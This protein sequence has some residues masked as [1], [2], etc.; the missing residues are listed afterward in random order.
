MVVPLVYYFGANASVALKKTSA[1]ANRYF[2]S[3]LLSL[4]QLAQV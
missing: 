1:P 4:L 3:L 2:E